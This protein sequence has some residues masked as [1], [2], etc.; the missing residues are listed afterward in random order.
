MS[1]AL[2]LRQTDLML[3]GP[4]GSLDQYIQQ[5]NA[6]EVLSAEEEHELAVRLQQDNDV[7]APRP[8]PGC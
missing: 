6:I 7:P 8:G 3:A 2:T 1:T 4:L 5:I